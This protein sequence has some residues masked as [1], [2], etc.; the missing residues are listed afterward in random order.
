V[1]GNLLFGLQSTAFLTVVAG[2]TEPSRRAAAFSYYQWWNAAALVVGPA[3]GAFWVLRHLRPAAYLACTGLVYLTVGLLRLWGLKDPRP[4]ARHKAPPLTWTRFW[5]SAAATAQRRRLLVLTAGV[6]TTFALTVNGPFLPL[7]TH[8]LDHMDMRQVDLFFGVG[9]VGALA[10]SSLAARLRSQRQALVWG[11]GVHAVASTL[12]AFPLP[13]LAVGVAYVA[14]FTGFQVATVAFS[15][16]RV[17]FA[18]EEAA[19]EV[20]GATSA[21]AGAVA[22]FGLTVG[23]FLGS[24]GSL[25]LAAAVALATA[26]WASRQLGQ[27]REPVIRLRLA[28]LPTAHLSR[29]R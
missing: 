10:S 27:G 21:L 18:G 8:A 24:R 13:R 15:T 25:W 16:L 2:S 3:A 17:E 19:G 4:D 28:L 1:A 7:A 6:T 14:A 9:A 5:H 11:L 20:L 22:F 29:R 12:L 26:L 23:G